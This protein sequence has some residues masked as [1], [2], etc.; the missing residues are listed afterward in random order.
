M[1]RLLN[2][3]GNYT[4]EAK[5]IAYLLT[6]AMNQIV[7]PLYNTYDPSDL[8]SILLNEAFSVAMSNQNKLIQ[9]RKRK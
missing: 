3:Q 6:S 5:A 4:D 8:K 9:S 2:H 7:E 1:E